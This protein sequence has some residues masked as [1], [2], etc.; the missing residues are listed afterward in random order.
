MGLPNLGHCMLIFREVRPTFNM[1]IP[2]SRRSAEG[3]SAEKNLYLGV[4]TIFSVFRLAASGLKD[5]LQKARLDIASRDE[6]IS[7]SARESEGILMRLDEAEARERK[8]E[9]ELQNSHQMASEF[10]AQLDMARQREEVMT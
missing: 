1:S 3:Q 5:E 2:G 6:R 7:R 8:L 9:A 10:M 4:I